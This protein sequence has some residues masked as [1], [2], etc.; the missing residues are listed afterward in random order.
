MPIEVS[1]TDQNVQVSTSG[2]TVNASV[3]GGVGPAGPTGPQ[4][5]AGATGPQGPAGAAGASAWADITGKPSTFA[6]SAHTHA[7]ADTTGLQAALD[8][9]APTDSPQFTNYADAARFTDDLGQ[10]TSISGGFVTTRRVTFA[11]DGTGVFQT[12]AFTGTLK[13]K[14]DGIATGATANATDAQLRDRATH[15]GTQAVG[16]LATTGTASASTYLRGDGAWTATPVTS[17]DGSTGAV[18]ITKHEVLDFTV[19]SKPSAATGSGGVYSYTV[20]AAAKAIR[21][22]CVG[23]GAGGGSGRRGATSTARGGGAGGSGA[24]AYSAF[25]AVAD[26]PS[27]ALTI[28]APS[29]G[30]GGAAATADNTDGSFGGNATETYVTSSGTKIVSAWVTSPGGN[31]T[32]SGG[33]IYS[34]YQGGVGGD[35]SNNGSPM[36]GGAGSATGAGANGEQTFRIACTGG[37]GGGAATSGNASG[38]GGDSWIPYMATSGTV[39]NTDTLQGGT[40]GGGNGANGQRRSGWQGPLGGGGSGGGGNASGAGGNGGNGAFPGG[41]G[42]GGGAS[43]NGNNS[44]AGGNGGGALVRITVYY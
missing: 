25:W 4:G 10:V 39:Y 30:A 44:G 8:G 7:I 11:T 36:R 18:T 15:T 32:T 6:P 42:G 34:T 23:G 20:P 1:V 19:S 5:P 12:T 27:T 41:G 37:G 31:G 2:Q 13:T 29:G 38:A 17:V 22:L 24:A 14:L 33:S 9:K 21:I 3:S 16:T 35:Y 40:A 26:L 43:L 28:Y